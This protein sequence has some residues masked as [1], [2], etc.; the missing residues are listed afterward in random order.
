[1]YRPLK[2]NTKLCSLLI[3]HASTLDA[4][5]TPD[6]YQAFRMK[7]EDSAEVRKSRDIA[8]RVSDKKRR[9]L[10]K[11][12]KRLVASH[13]MDSFPSSLSQRVGK[14]PRHPAR[15]ARKIVAALLHVGRSCSVHLTRV[16]PRMHPFPNPP[17]IHSLPPICP[18]TNGPDVR[19]PA[20]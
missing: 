5:L 16:R 6:R 4:V 11:R 8:L 20:R 7:I 10:S 12:S 3:P 1:M 13:G 15:L 17:R 14:L 18:L 19:E 9:P 2:L